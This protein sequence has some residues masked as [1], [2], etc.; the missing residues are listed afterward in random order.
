MPEKE[1][2]YFVFDFDGVICDSTNECMVTAWNAWN[3]WN[4]GNNYRNKLSSFSKDEISSF[5]S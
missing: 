3:R 1:Y 2:K 5:K 4:G